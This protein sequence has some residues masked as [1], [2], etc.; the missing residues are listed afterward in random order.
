[1]TAR[2]IV[3]VFEPGGCVEL[4]LLDEPRC[5]GCEGVCLWRRL[6]GSRRMRLSASREWCA[7]DPVLVALPARY[8]LLGA[9][10]LYGF[11]WAALLAGALAGAALSGTDLGVLIGAVLGV[12]AALAAAPRL[13]RRLESM[14]AERIELH[15]PL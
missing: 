4:E 9:M 10:L 14:T 3:R 6:P 13:R 12:T 8:V 15:A 5:R 7:G 2:A 11:P 1:M